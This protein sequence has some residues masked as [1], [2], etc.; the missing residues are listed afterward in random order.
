M[1]AAGCSQLFFFSWGSSAAEPENTLG[2][3]PPAS[4]PRCHPSGM[5]YRSITHTDP[6]D[7]PLAIRESS[8]LWGGAPAQRN[9]RSHPGLAG[10]AMGT[11]GLCSPAALFLGHD[12]PWRRPRA[13][14]GVLPPGGPTPASGG[15][16]QAGHARGCGQPGGEGRVPAGRIGPAP[17]P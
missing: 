9:P 7:S 11:P 14:D 15:S 4:R 6:M 3:T 5:L 13:L 1:S 2:E 16:E 17:A 10:R 8:G 12:T